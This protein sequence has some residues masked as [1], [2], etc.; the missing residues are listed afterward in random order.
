MLTFNILSASALEKI[1]NRVIALDPDV[2]GKRQKLDQKR[3]AI[4]LTD[5]SLTYVFYFTDEKIIVESTKQQDCQVTLKG[6]SFAFFNMASQ[7]NGGDAL[8]KGE[9][10]FEGEIGTAQ[11]FQTFWSSLSIDWEEHLS[12]YT[13]DIIAHQAG[14]LF[15][16]AQQQA[17]HILQTAKLNTSEYL[18]EEALMTPSV[19]E[20]EHFYEQLD[21]LKSDVNRFSARLQRLQKIMTQN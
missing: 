21:D 11:S 18:R 3:V 6:S 10:H 9:V 16:K 13:G 5:W 1:I 8:F 2:S 19:V 14:H 4:E 7:E 15:K 12:S 17:K 20:V